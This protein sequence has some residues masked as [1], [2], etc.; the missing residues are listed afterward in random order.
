M[1]ARLIL[2]SRLSISSQGGSARGTP[3]PGGLL[4]LGAPK[5]KADKGRMGSASAT[6]SSSQVQGGDSGSGG[7]G[8]RCR[9]LFLPPEILFRI[10]YVYQNNVLLEP[11]CRNG[12]KRP[13]Q[14][15]G[16][17]NRGPLEALNGTKLILI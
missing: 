3:R 5:P 12:K 4:G 8:S 9:C 14:E 1:V 11:V 2:E 16:L 7:R 15:T 6:V 13:N 17:R 10:T